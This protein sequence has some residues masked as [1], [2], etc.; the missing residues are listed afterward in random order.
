[1]LR[2]IHTLG[3][4]SDASK[5]AESIAGAFIATLWG[6]SSANLVYLPIGDKLKVRHEEEQLYLDI[7]LEGVISIQAGEIPRVIRTKLLSFLEPG[8]RTE[9]QKK[10]A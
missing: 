10:A 9:P 3:N 7:A 2:L 6:V 4:T 8:V 5:M 1:M